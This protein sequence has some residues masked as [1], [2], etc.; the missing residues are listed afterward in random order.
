M[1]MSM[2]GMY[3]RACLPIQQA[4]ARL[5]VGQDGDAL[6]VS[7]CWQHAVPAA[8]QLSVRQRVHNAHLQKRQQHQQ[9]LVQKSRP[10]CCLHAA[11][12]A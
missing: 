10:Q 8:R 12:G 4:L 3:G 1:E 9:M 7:L 6:Q 11:R 5:L 2:K